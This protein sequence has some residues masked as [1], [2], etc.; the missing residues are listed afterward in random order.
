MGMKL[1]SHQAHQ[2]YATAKYGAAAQPTPDSQPY[3]YA[4]HALVMAHGLM[5]AERIINRRNTEVLAAKIVAPVEALVQAAAPDTA[6]KADIMELSMVLLR[7]L[8]HNAHRLTVFI[9]I[10][11]GQ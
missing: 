2:Q 5:P 6:A 9:P 8:A 11:T 4:R 7:Q 3:P 1:L 10:V